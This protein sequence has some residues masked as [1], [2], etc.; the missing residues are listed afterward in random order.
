MVYSPS[1]AKH[2]AALSSA[3]ISSFT[4]ARRA[5]LM[6]MSPSGAVS[7]SHARGRL[8]VLPLTMSHFAMDLFRLPY[9]RGP[10]SGPRLCSA[11]RHIANY[12]RTNKLGIV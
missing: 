11:N 1:P 10:T 3:G 12:V 8:L 6:L 4:H 9:T 2:G 5:W 7:K